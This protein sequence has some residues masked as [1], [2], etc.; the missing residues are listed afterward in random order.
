MWSLMIVETSP[1]LDQHAGVSHADEPPPVQAFV[2]QFAIKA[3][4]GAMLPRTARRDEGGADILILQPAHT[5][6]AVN[7]APL[8]ERM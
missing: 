2:A 7:G 5:A 6:A 1:L 4:H 3:L 8:S